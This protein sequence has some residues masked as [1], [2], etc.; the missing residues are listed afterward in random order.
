MRIAFVGKGGSG[1]TTIASLFAEYSVSLGGRVLALDADIN[2]H[3]AGALGFEGKLRSMGV[4]F[5]EIKSHL[6][7]TNDRFSAEEMSKTTPP[8]HGS[9]FITL[10]E[11]DWFIKRYTKKAGQIMLAGA[12]DIPEGNVGVRCYHGL[13]GAIELVLG[14]LLDTQDDT[15]IVDMT[16]GADAF[17]SSLFAKVDA[18]VLVVEPTLKS[19]SVYDQF[20]PNVQKYDIPFLVVG[21]KI[22]DDDDRDF[23]EQRIG[24][25]TA[26][27]GQSTF[28]RKRER[29]VRTD[30]LG[31]ENELIS[32]L[33][34]LV[35][36]TRSIK[37]D[38]S[39]L[40]QRSHI[41]H[42]KNAD[43]WMGK[44]AAEHIDPTFSLQDF[45][46]KEM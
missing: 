41:L 8:G 43:D 7:G 25:L 29:G 34:K 35:L 12:G 20:L 3:L 16:A 39:K 23:I 28:I 21:N 11:G 22:Q 37:R 19:L 31:A 30:I 26:H 46:R 17:S 6:R 15:V 10:K 1:K 45:A 44:T 24:T 32:H 33:H 18:L 36:A 5:D 42:Q 4:E 13:N 14:H 9:E 2:Q 38:W 40:E 27:L